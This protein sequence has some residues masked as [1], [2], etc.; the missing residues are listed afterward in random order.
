MMHWVGMLTLFP[1]YAVTSIAFVFSGI[2]VCLALTS[3]PDRVGSL[4][5]AD[6]AGAAVGCLLLPVV[7][8]WFGGPTAVIAAA[9]VAAS[10]AACF[11]LA[12]KR[13]LVVAAVANTILIAVLIPFNLQHHF[14]S[15]V[16]V[17][18]EQE[19]PV[20]YEKWNSFSRLRVIDD[21]DKPLGWGVSMYLP[22]RFAGVKQLRL[23]IDASAA[24]TLTKSDGDVSKIGSLAYDVSSCVH[25]LRPKA[26]VAVVGVG[27]GTDIL[28]AL[29]F[30]QRS[31]VGIELNHDIL[32]LLTNKYGDYTGHLDRNPRVRLVEDEARSWLSKSREKFDIIQISLIDTWAATSAGAFALSENSLYTKECWKLLVDHLSDHGILSCSR[33]YYRDRQEECYR[34]LEL[35]KTALIEAGITDDPRKHIILMTNLVPDKSGY[36]AD[37]GIGNLMLSKEGFTDADVQAAEFVAKAK[38]FRILLSPQSAN[39]P[40]MGEILSANGERFVAAYPLNISAPTDDS[41]FF[42]QLARLTDWSQQIVNARTP[43][44]YINLIAITSLCILLL[45]V[46]FLTALSIIVPLVL[47]RGKFSLKLASPHLIYF[48]SIGFA[49]M[50]VEISQIQRMSVFLGHPTYGLLVVL[51]TLLLS[52]GLGSLSTQW[53][54]PAVDQSGNAGNPSTSALR[55]LTAI[56]LALPVFTLLTPPVIQAFCGAPNAVRIATAVAILSPMG[57]LMGGAFPL[58]MRVSCERLSALTPWFWGLNGAASVLA[59]VLAVVLSIGF[60]ITVTCFAGIGFYVLALLSMLAIGRQH[61][62]PEPALDEAA[63]SEALS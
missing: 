13:K 24:T 45:T 54:L 7:L 35:A 40:A 28:S 19:R 62:A 10:G 49:Y 52:S 34:L 50:L 18:G 6:L 8:S 39:D 59:S 17:K 60:G 11:A 48:S 2:C 31:V 61:A 5:A 41:P 53:L 56:L 44:Q 37:A 43:G 15:L 3:Y 58:G 26:N 42:F 16:W 33:W 29:F 57:F 32:D 1:I 51:F 9:L 12:D 63:A 36:V 22:P 14:L 46:V 20:L 38:H 23:D 47:T 27:G 55:W 4:Y 25:Y 30:N 21:G